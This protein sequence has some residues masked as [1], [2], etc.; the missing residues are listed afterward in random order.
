MRWPIIILISIIIINIALGQVSREFISPS[1]V[2]TSSFAGESRGPSVVYINPFSEVPFSIT[3]KIIDQTSNELYVND[4]I[5]I[6]VEIKYSGSA[7]IDNLRIWEGVDSGLEIIGNS[8]AY[9]TTSPNEVINAGNGPNRVHLRNIYDDRVKISEK[10]LENRSFNVYA[11]KILNGQSIVIVYQLKGLKAGTMNTYTI[12]RYYK[13][14][15]SMKDYT[16]SLSINFKEPSPQFQTRFDVRKL[17]AVEGEDIPLTYRISYMGGMPYNP[18]GFDVIYDTSEDYSLDKNQS[19]NVT[20]FKNKTILIH[21]NV[22][23]KKKKKK[24]KTPALSCVV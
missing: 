20:L 1:L 15:S 8:S 18:C 5:Y 10:D 24:K 7:P 11:T 16:S 9:I 3:K 2:E 23:Y 13:D 14:Y 6:T 4:S 21:N 19:Q 12:V 17:T 22:E